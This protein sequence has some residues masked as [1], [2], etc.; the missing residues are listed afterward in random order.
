MDDQRIQSRLAAVMEH[1]PCSLAILSADATPLLAGGRGAVLAAS[2]EVRQAVRAAADAGR[3]LSLRVGDVRLTPFGEEGEWLLCETD[4]DTRLRFLGDALNAVTQGK[5]HLVVDGD[6]LPARLPAVTEVAL[7]TDAALAP[8]RKTV[9]QSALSAGVPE[10][11]ARGAATAV[12][13][14]AMNAIVHGGGG[15]AVVGAASDTPGGGTVQVWIEDRGPGIVLDQ[16]SRSALVAGYSTRDSMGMG[17]YLTLQ[18]AD[19]VFLRTDSSGT[20]V[21]VETDQHPTLPL[22]LQR[23]GFEAGDLATLG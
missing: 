9:L 8:L 4:E 14:I 11:R 10:M 22:W 6:G 7:D 18:E 20:L 16:L 23:A 1:S 21:V 13:E 19:R 2:P 5:L 15:R 3:R 12:G 17:F